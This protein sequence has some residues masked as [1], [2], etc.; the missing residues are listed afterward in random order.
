MAGGTRD[1]SGITTHCDNCSVRLITNGKEGLERI[2]Q[3]GLARLGPLWNE[4]LNTLHRPLEHGPLLLRARE[5][6]VVIKVFCFDQIKPKPPSPEVLQ[7][8]FRSRAT[9]MA[10]DAII[11]T[12]PWSMGWQTCA[13]LTTW[14]FY[15][16][17]GPC[18]KKR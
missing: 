2:L 9:F 16:S 13:H 15:F 4:V 3:R 8:H 5:K 14:Y 12:P 11:P 17:S 18:Q 10:R 6:R 1:S 7:T